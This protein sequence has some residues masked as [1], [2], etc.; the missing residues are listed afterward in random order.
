MRTWAFLIGLCVLACGC[1]GLQGRP[2]PAA[3]GAIVLV[4][5]AGDGKSHPARV[6]DVVRVRLD[7]V[8]G[9]VW[10]VSRQTGDALG[11]PFEAAPEAR[12]RTPELLGGPAAS[13]FLFAA[14]KVGGA[15]ISFVRTSKGRPNR[16][17]RITVS[18]KDPR[19]RR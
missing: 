1:A 17:V 4:T 13:V 8:T 19:S 14:R 15:E 7:A 18:V 16:L 10:R 9:E 5:Q 3:G 6:G 11:P 2:E 12:D